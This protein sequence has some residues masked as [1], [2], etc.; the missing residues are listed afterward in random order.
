MTLSPTAATQTGDTGGSAKTSGHIR[1]SGTHGGGGRGL[2]GAFCPDW[3][4]YLG[5]SRPHPATKSAQI[6]YKTGLVRPD[7]TRPQPAGGGLSQRGAVQAALTF[8][9]YL[10][11]L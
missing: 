7:L 11:A 4:E 10:S 6:V 5:V 3:P 8:V 2:A 1:D 9:A